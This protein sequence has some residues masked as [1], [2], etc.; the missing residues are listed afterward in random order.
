ML[1]FGILLFSSCCFFF[2]WFVSQGKHFFFYSKIRFGSVHRDA[3]IFFVFFFSSPFFVSVLPSISVP[4]FFNSLAQFQRIKHRKKT[5]I[6]LKISLIKTARKDHSKITFRDITSLYKRL[7]CIWTL[8]VLVQTY[9]KNDEKKKS[10][11]FCPFHQA[12][13]PP[14]SLS[15]SIPSLTWGCLRAPFP[16]ITRD[17]CWP[18][19]LFFPSNG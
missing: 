4:F 9:G 6:A 12:P 15:L 7:N 3:S 2:S 19:K 10:A 5:F 13:S 17:K 1:L 18:R 11:S 8:L 14:T 16:F